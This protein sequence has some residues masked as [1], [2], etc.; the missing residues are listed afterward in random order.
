ME[1]QLINDTRGRNVTIPG[2]V[3]TNANTAEISERPSWLRLTTGIAARGALPGI[4]LAT[5]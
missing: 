4:Q 2:G 1:R 3:G 5:V